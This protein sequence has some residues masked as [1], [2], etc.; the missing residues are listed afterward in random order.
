MG[1]FSYT[2]MVRISPFSTKGAGSISG[3]R[4]KIP[5]ALQPETQNIKQKQYSIKWN[6]DSFFKKG[7]SLWLFTKNII[8]PSVK[9][10]LQLSQ[11]DDYSEERTQ[12]I[13]RKKIY[14]HGHFSRMYFFNHKSTNKYSS[15][16]SFMFKPCQVTSLASL[17]SAQTKF[18]LPLN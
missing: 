13:S 16:D 15:S 1:E 11:V 4:A 5:H 9:Y 6:N 8:L 12:V 3:Q 17:A 7:G 10:Y 18:F 2:P 14:I